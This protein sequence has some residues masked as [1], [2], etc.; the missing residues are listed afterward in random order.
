MRPRVRPSARV[1]TLGLIVL[2]LLSTTP[3]AAAAGVPGMLTNRYPLGTQT[4]CCQTTSPKSSSSASSTTSHRSASAP[5]TQAPATQAPA[6]PSLTAHESGAGRRHPRRCPDRARGRRGPRRVLH[7]VGDLGASTQAQAPAAP[8]PANADRDHRGI[9]E[10]C[11]THAVARSRPDPASPRTPGQAWRSTP[12]LRPSAPTLSS[13]DAGGVPSAPPRLSPHRKSRDSPGRCRSTKSEMRGRTRSWRSPAPIPKRCGWLQAQIG[14]LPDPDRVRRLIARWPEALAGSSDLVAIASVRHAEAL[15]LWL[16]AADGWEH[17]AA[18]S[19]DGDRGD[20]LVRAAIDA[21][22]AGD[23][24]RHE[25]LLTNAADVDPDC[26]RL[27]LSRF[28]PDSRPRDQ[29]ARLERIDT[30]DASLG[31]IVACQKALT[32]LRLGDLD[33]AAEHLARAQQLGPESVR[34]PRDRDQPPRPARPG[35]AQLEPDGS[36][37]PRPYRRSRTRSRSGR[38]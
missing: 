20:R 22:L 2:S 28:D 13:Q 15:G 14:Q 27:H 33:S 29:L 26:P 23:D 38:R 4:L 9:P 34:D 5:A 35:R 6:S 7:L 3:A 21:E 12:L 19:S 24:A 31:V 32:S 17:F 36:R 10:R 37:L 18:Q 30:E 11:R 25:H 8:A 16:D 1:T